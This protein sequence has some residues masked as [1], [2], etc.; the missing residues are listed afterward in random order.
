MQIC[1]CNIFAY[2]RFTST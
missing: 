2:A 1:D